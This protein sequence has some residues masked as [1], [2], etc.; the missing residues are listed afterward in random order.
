MYTAFYGLREKP[1][2]L[3]PDPRFLYLADSHR[4]ALAHLLYGIEQHEGFMAIT[5]EVGTGKTTI[6]RTLLERLG[7]GTEV[8]LRSCCSP[9]RPSLGSAAAAT[10]AT[11]ST[12][13]SIAS[14]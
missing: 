4:E 11:N 13:S 5:G 8:G 1:F 9:S 14:C 12:I 6:C 10:A 2:S 7:S 3:S